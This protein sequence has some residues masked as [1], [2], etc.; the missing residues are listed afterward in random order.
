MPIA[1]LQIVSPK[2]GAALGRL[3]EF[4]LTTVERPSDTRYFVKHDGIL[5]PEPLVAASAS[6][7]KFAPEAP[8]A[9][10]IYAFWRDASG[11]SRW[12]ET[13][14]TIEGPPSTGAPE[15]VRT[16]DGFS[17]WTP[18]SWEA[19]L[20]GQHEG[21]ALDALGR[22]IA[23]GATVYDVGANIGLFATRFA[24]WVGASGHVYCIEPNPLCVY[25]LRANLHVSGARNF[26]I[27]PVC[28][29]DSPRPIEFTVNYGSSVLGMAPDSTFPVKHGHRIAVEGTSLDALIDKLH[30]RAP[31][32]IKIDVEGAEGVAVA[33]MMDT[34]SRHKPLLMI[35]LHGVPAARA[36]L[37][38]LAPLGY[39]YQAIADGRLFPSSGELAA[40]MPDACVQVMALR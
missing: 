10:T 7:V 36:A 15:R 34:L 18:S 4:A 19:A 35:E 12:A 16:H 11:E 25:F 29:T 20:A 37:A 14:F 33:G 27:L 40:W 28:L 2:G 31:D 8:G 21:R 17:A 1:S 9:Y 39:T 32:V 22:L 26:D 24:K 13:T 6:S 5:Y 30:L 38:H 3:T 23:P